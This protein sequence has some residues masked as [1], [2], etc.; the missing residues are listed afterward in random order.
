M[1]AFLLICCLTA[2][3]ST[4]Q[5]GHNISSLNPCTFIVQSFVKENLFLFK[6]FNLTLTSQA[7]MSKLTDSEAESVDYI[8][9]KTRLYWIILNTLFIL[10][11]SVGAVSSKF[12]VDRLSRRHFLLMHNSFSITGGVLTLL[13]RY[14]KSPVCLLLSRLFF[15]LQSGLSKFSNFGSYPSMNKFN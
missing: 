4:F 8:N 7:N 5:S 13:A 10:G 1:N 2:A 6:K 15:G 3:S 11:G 14:Q 12:G 9:D